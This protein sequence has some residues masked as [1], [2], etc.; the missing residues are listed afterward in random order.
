MIFLVVFHVVYQLR[1]RG[2]IINN[3]QVQISVCLSQDRLHSFSKEVHPLVEYRHHNCNRWLLL[4]CRLW[5][6]KEC[7]NMH[8]VELIVLVKV[9]IDVGVRINIRIELIQIL[10]WVIDWRIVNW[11]DFVDCDNGEWSRVET[12]TVGVV[13]GKHIHLDYLVALKLESI[14]F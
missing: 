8:R 6:G 1:I 12:E 10:G 11:L 2:A 5:C 3:N 13:F 4:L 7:P 9:K 14:G